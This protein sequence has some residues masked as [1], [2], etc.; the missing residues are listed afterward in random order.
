[1]ITGRT[2]A[3]ERGQEHRDTIRKKIK[4]LKY[5]ADFMLKGLD[6]CESPEHS[7]P[8]SEVISALSITTLM[9]RAFEVA[10]EAALNNGAQLV[11]VVSDD[12][13][14][15]SPLSAAVSHESHSVPGATRTGA[16]HEYGN[17]DYRA[18]LV[19]DDPKNCKGNPNWELFEDDEEG[20]GWH[21]RL[22]VVYDQTCE[23]QVEIN[24][25]R[26]VV[27]AQSCAI[28]GSKADG[29]TLHFVAAGLGYTPARDDGI[30]LR[31]YEEPA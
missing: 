1:M 8:G 18:A 27:S 15:V 28:R 9:E 16:V 21:I 5:W 13:A 14:P 20:D 3:K 31:I 26:E 24:G 12:D 30:M 4:E 11:Q 29:F 25:L 10:Y 22:P 23:L 7:M 19:S 17:I 2:D 6:T